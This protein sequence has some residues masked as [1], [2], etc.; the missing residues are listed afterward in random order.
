MR[1][2]LPMNRSSVLCLR[3]C[4]CVSRASASA[5][6]SVVRVR[7]LVLGLGARVCASMR[8]C[9]LHTAVLISMLSG[10]LWSHDREGTPTAAMNHCI[11]EPALDGA[12]EGRK[13]GGEERR[14]EERKINGG[15]LG[16][17]KTT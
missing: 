3:A 5:C 10:R 1:S 6:A 15:G 11:I 8:L 7:V 12:R 16:G 17:R 4:A 14:G 9:A 13:E 2:D